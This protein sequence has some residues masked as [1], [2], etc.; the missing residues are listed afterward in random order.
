MIAWNLWSEGKTPKT[1][2]MKGDHFMGQY[3]VR[4]K[5]EAEKEPT[6]KD[7]V[8]KCL[9]LWEQEDPA[10][11][12]LWKKTQR[13]VLDGIEE[14][15]KT[16][17]V[18]FDKIF[19]ESA[20][21]K[22]GVALVEKGI[23]ENILQYD[24]KGNVIASL[25]T[26][27]KLP[28]LVLIRSDGTSVYAT[29]D[30]YLA[31]AKNKRFKFHK[32]LYV[33]GNEQKLYFQQLFA[34]LDFLGFQ[35]IKNC[36]HIAYALVNLPEGRMKSREGKVVDADEL[37]KET[38]ELVKQELKAREEKLSPKELEKRSQLIALAAIKYYILQIDSKTTIIFDP[39]KSITLN[40]R[41]GPYLQYTTARIYSILKKIP[42]KLSRGKINP[43]VLTTE[44]EH[45]ILLLLAEFPDV[46]LFGAHH[47]EPSFLAKYLYEL[48]KNFSIFYEKHKI[49]DENNME[50]SRAR[51]QFVKNILLVLKKGLSI[52]GNEVPERM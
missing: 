27:Y 10:T 48:A 12:K 3:Y 42:L 49:I 39:K 14:T 1:E 45:N 50:L 30:L 18:K 46:L 21:Y 35:P 15:Y 38:K 25:E 28:P 40:G 16:L 22:K 6:L 5:K 17:G 41:T 19:Y 44:E 34:T 26:F 36:E 32:S 37:I 43:R 8:Q 33:V 51:I 7:E 11:R 52:L 2:N 4:F 13:W 29:Q 20:I 31:H 47:Y 24:E 9:K 23:R